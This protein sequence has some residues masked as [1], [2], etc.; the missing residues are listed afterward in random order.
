MA[1]QKF[2]AVRVGKTPGVYE[3][4]EE[5]EQ[6]VK[7][8]S[9]AV[10]KSFSSREEANA[11][12]MIETI[13]DSTDGNS[14]N[15]ISDY[16]N[17]IENAIASSRVVAFVDGGFSDKGGEP[18]A[19]YGCLIIPPD[20][21]DQI[22]ISDR[23]YTDKFIESRNIAPEIFAS[24][25]ALKWTL[26]NGYKSITVFHDLE[27]TGKWARGEYQAKSDISRFFVKELNDTFFP[28]LDINFIW[29]KAHAGIEYNERADQLAS[30]ALKNFRKPVGK[31]GPN[32]FTGR[33]VSEE[34]VLAIIE[35]LKNI[36]GVN[37]RQD[38]NTAAEKRYVL[39][40]V[41]EKKQEKL[42]VT[43][44]SDKRTTLT[45]R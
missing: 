44:Y 2:Y 28:L 15:K 25:E 10:F 26:A 14:K 35:E 36:E 23:V 5:C 4:W 27:N 30:E 39:K 34:K 11:F 45:S 19:A 9:G 1:K 12:L 3:S 20:G 16:N 42:T 6:Q 7:G 22:E 31:Y 21:S 17:D 40:R 41:Y 38:I 13:E 24:L 37:V 29:V 33:N 43:F 18:V 8:V 32:F